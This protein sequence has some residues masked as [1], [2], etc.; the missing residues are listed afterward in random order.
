MSTP[1]SSMNIFPRFAAVNQ[2][3]KKEDMMRDLMKMIES[4]FEGTSGDNTPEENV[5]TEPAGRHFRIKQACRTVLADM[6]REI[7]AMGHARI[8]LD[9]KRD[10]LIDEYNL[11]DSYVFQECDVPEFTDA[12]LE[13][14][15]DVFILNSMPFAS[16]PVGSPDENLESVYCYVIIEKD[17]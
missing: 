6:K 10:A 4:L 2:N 14:M 11:M 13:Q 3:H 7:D 9:A 16:L 17:E 15:A 1:L 12:E 5:K 8:A